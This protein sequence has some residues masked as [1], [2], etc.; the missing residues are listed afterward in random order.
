MPTC[1]F[2]TEQLAAKSQNSS[3]RREMIPSCIFYIIT[4]LQIQDRNSD[5]VSLLLSE[6]WFRSSNSAQVQMQLED[7][8]AVSLRSGDYSQ[9]NS[10]MHWLS[11]KPQFLLSQWS[12]SEDTAPQIPPPRHFS[13]PFPLMSSSLRSPGWNPSLGAGGSLAIRR[14]FPKQLS[15]KLLHSAW[16]SLVSLPHSL[17][18]K[19][20]V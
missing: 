2:Q 17:L 13:T 6:F 20:W 14:E 19:S 11:W 18:A 8:R 7:T 15:F 4:K 16:V 10:H 1:T 3:M 12:L 9:D 5:F